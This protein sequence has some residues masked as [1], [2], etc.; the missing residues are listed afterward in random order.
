MATSTAISTNANLPALAA[1]LAEALCGSFGG[2]IIRKKGRVKGGTLYGDDLVHVVFITGFIYTNLLRRSLEKARTVKASDLLAACEARGLTGKN[3]APLTVNDCLVAI[4]ATIDSLNRSLAGTN[5]STTDHVY[6]PLVVDSETVRGCRVYTGAGDPSNPKAP[7]PGT[8]YLNVLKIGQK[9]LEPAANG[10]IPAANSRGD[11]V[12]KS[13]LRS[14]LPIG[15]YVSYAL[16]PGAEFILRAGGTAAVAAD[17]DG[18]SVRSA[19]VEDIFTLAAA[20]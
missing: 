16:E 20:V 9:V 2:L 8:I 17:C 3:G 15:R 5:T 14:M 18:V 4:D 11:V 6:E 1:T 10:P 19:A 7:I 13:I 12:A